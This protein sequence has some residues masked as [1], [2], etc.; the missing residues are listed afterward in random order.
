MNID[1]K[2]KEVKNE[3]EANTKRSECIKLRV[4]PITKGRLK[5]TANLLNVSANELINYVLNKVLI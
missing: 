1:V 4:S 5:N 2:C 3:I